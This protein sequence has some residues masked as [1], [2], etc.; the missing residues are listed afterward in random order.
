MIFKTRNP[1]DGLYI[2]VARVQIN[3]NQIN[4][5]M[6]GC[7]IMKKSREKK[8]SSVLLKIFKLY[9]SKFKKKIALELQQAI[10]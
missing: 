3:P 4:F 6:A 8:I 9:V 5:I 1:N 7:T 10:W 2:F